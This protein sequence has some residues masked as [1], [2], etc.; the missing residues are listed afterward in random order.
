MHCKPD[1]MMTEYFEIV[2]EQDRVIGK[3]PRSQC[4]GDPSLVHRV[5]H[6]LVLNKKGHLLLQKRSPHKDIQPD[7][8]DTSV[9]G[10]LNVGEDYETAA[11]REMKEELGIDGPD[12]E[13]LYAYP[14]R[15]TIE[16]ENVQT[17]LCH[18][19]G[20]ISYNPDEITQVRSWA[21]DEIE[22]NL[23][24]GI[25][26]PNFEEEYQYY[27]DAVSCQRSAISKDQ[28]KR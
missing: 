4:H 16:S 27:R 28:K 7:K 2:D 19:D 18:Y 15:N 20:E 6:V 11:Y 25:F 1:T 5:A 24:S 22:K 17:Y 12:L 3:A 21:R 9:G 10:H 23:G 26:T 13:F 8:W 14:L